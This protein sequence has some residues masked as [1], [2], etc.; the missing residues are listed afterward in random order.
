MRKQ[1]LEKLRGKSGT[2]TYSSNK[3]YGGKTTGTSAYGKGKEDRGRGKYE[4]HHQNEATDR[5]SRFGKNR[6]GGTDSRAQSDTPHKVNRN[7]GVKN[8]RYAKETPE[9]ATQ[10]PLNKF[11][12]H[13]GICGRREAAEL[14]KQGQVQVNGDIVFEPATKVSESDT[15]KLKGKTLSIQQ[16]LVYFLLN[17]PKDHITTTKDDKGRKTVLDLFKDVDEK[18]VF[19]VGRLDRNTTGVLLLTNDGELAQELTHPSFEVKKIYEATLDKPLTKKDAD[20]IAT[21]ITL[22]D[23]E[24]KADSVGYADP[25]N[26]SVI[27]IEI[28]S[29]KNRIVRRIFEHLGYEVKKLD[30]VMFAGL[31]KKNVDRGKWRYLSEKEIRILKFMNAGGT[32]KS[33]AAAAINGGDLPQVDAE[34]HPRSK[35]ATP[36]KRKRIKVESTG[37]KDHVKA[38]PKPRENTRERSREDTRGN[39]RDNTRGN[40]RDNPRENTRGNSRDNT[41]GNTRENTRGNTRETTREN[42]RPAR[43]ASKSPVKNSGGKK[44]HSKRSIKTHK[45]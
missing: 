43:P 6:T 13:A 9:T 15:I 32:K 25:K 20:A 19:P 7:F 37:P 26:K 29:G 22:E 38:K 17:K 36:V 28:H 34:P 40:T 14:V 16:K 39:S 21:G 31:T 45:E 8:E 23:G 10:M 42:S 33:K 5:N 4:S 44:V 35:S 30:R 1:K 11:I 3:L 18:H 12:A 41:R 2:E 24:I 27:G